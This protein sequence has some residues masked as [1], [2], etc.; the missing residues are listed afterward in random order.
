MY[1]GMNTELYTTNLLGYLKGFRE[2]QYLNSV[3]KSEWELKF[4]TAS[5]EEGRGCSKGL[6]CQEHFVHISVFRG[7]HA[8]AYMKIIY[9]YVYK[10]GRLGWKD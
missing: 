5:L 9:M 3:V 8:Y 6:G 10:N 7:L 1:R 2:K 4:V